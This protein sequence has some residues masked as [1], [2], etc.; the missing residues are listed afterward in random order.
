MNASGLK[1]GGGKMAKSLQS[2]FAKYYKEKLEPFG[3]QKVKGRQPYFVRVVN[4][5]IL[6]ILWSKL[7]EN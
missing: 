4:D 5:E 2:A 1:K 3:F 7:L 6:N